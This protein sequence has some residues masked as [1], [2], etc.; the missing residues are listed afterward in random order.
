MKVKIYALFNPV[1]NKIRYIGR[2]KG[3]LNKRLSSHISK[4]KNCKKYY[5]N[6]NYPHNTNWIN[7]LLKDG[8]TPGIRF[9]KEVEG[10]EE[11]HIEEKKLIQKHLLK[12][13]LVNGD[14]R[15]SGFTGAKN[16]YKPT[17][18]KRVNKI[19]THFSKEE[20]KQ[21]FYNKVYMYNI[22]GVLIKEFKSVKFIEEELG[23][24]KSRVTNHINRLNNNIK[25]LALEG[26][27]FSHTK[28]DTYPFIKLLPDN[29]VTV[30]IDNVIY[31]D[32]KN[33]LKK[34]FNLTNWDLSQLYNLKFTKSVLKIFKN[35]K[36]EIIKNNRAVLERNF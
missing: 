15:G 14:D 21:N 11:S 25:P 5:P 10:W 27:F 23:I 12:H 16:I 3:S 36:V 26:Y 31:T 20:N 30:I 32:L 24:K 7:S 33:T 2:T 17:E 19:K 4:S 9:L 8:I 34:Y 28:Y 18:E 29:R 1:N 6:G 22:Q 13:N 35:K